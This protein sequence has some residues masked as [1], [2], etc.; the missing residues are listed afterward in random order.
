MMRRLLPFVFVILAGCKSKDKI[1]GGVLP[2]PKMQVVLRDIMRADKF[3]SD[4]VLSR[5]SSLNKDSVRI[6]YYKAIFVIHKITKKEFQES[7]SYY[8]DHPVYLKS[9]LD[10][11]ST[12][13][14]PTD[15]MTPV[16]AEDT[17]LKVTP[18]NIPLRPADT[19]RPIR[20]FKRPLHTQ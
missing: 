13:K 16:D 20:Q 7:F 11:I 18:S 15:V 19:G 6:E 8:K 9:V 17:A 5:D 1:P 2:P 3:L 10:S 14:A 4:Y 12:T